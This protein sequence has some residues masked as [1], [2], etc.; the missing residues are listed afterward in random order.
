[1]ETLLKIPPKA[2][3][4][5]FLFALLGS[6][7]ITMIFLST[8]TGGVMHPGYAGKGL[9]LYLTGIDTIMIAIVCFMKAYQFASQ[10]ILSDP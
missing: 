4:L 6:G 7:G 10:K 1:M 9:V 3:V 5:L 2:I 8:N